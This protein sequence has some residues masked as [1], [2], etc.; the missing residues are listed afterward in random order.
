MLPGVGVTHADAVDVP[1]HED[2]QR[3]GAY[4]GDD[5]SEAVEPHLVEAEA[6]VLEPNAL[7]ALG[8]VEAFGRYGD[9]LAQE[10]N[11]LA[12]VPSRL[13]ESGPT[14][15]RKRRIRIQATLIRHR[16]HRYRD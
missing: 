16:S 8:L 3:P 2:R 1:V 15:G 5:V 4:P 10:A 9:H 11:D 13:L 12:L 6:L 7:T 14:F